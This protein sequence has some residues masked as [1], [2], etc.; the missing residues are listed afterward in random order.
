MPD[1]DANKYANLSRYYIEQAE[2]YL[3]RGNLLQASEKSWG[4]ATCALKSI[5][6]EQGWQHQSHSLLYDISNQIADQ[7]NRPDMSAMLSVAKS[8]HQNFYENLMPEP[9]VAYGVGS[10]REFLAELESVRQSPPP[11]FTPQTRAQ[12]RRLAR[13]TAQTEPAV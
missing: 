8:R 1:S 5:A 13:L 2:A 3:Q 6:E 7:F 4:A 11:P 9:E 12:R 10:A